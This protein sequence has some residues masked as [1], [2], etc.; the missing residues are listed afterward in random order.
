MTKTL[1]VCEKALMVLGKVICGALDF[2]SIMSILFLMS[3]VDYKDGAWP[4][5][6]M[7]LLVPVLWA[8]VR[9]TLKEAFGWSVWPMEDIDFDEF[10][11]DDFDDEDEEPEEIYY[12][13]G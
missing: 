5:M 9:T 11:Y 1:N 13:A 7:M 8:I 3:I 4:I 2:A 12:R 10:E 6:V